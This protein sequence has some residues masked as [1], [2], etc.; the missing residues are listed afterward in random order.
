M[1]RLWPPFDPK[2]KPPIWLVGLFIIQAV[3]GFLA[4]IFY[5][6]TYDLVFSGVV[7]LCGVLLT[8]MT[9]YHRVFI[10]KDEGLSS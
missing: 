6:D 1:F 10:Y 9:V 2:Y 5:E 4:A 7:S 8:L 3:C